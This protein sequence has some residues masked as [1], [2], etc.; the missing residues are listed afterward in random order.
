MGVLSYREGIFL[1]IV[2]DPVGIAMPL[3]RERKLNATVKG[4]ETRTEDGD[5]IQRRKRESSGTG[6]GEC[7]FGEEIVRFSGRR[8]RAQAVRLL[9]TF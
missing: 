7:A 6:H 9:L 2:S 4:I 8:C 1:E 5:G 3:L